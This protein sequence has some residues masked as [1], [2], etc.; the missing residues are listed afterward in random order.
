MSASTIS[1]L[2]GFVFGGMLGMMTMCV[3]I[4]GDDDGQA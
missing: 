4:V 2:L 1:F 3:L